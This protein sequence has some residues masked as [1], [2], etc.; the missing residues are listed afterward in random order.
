MLTIVNVNTTLHIY[1]RKIELRTVFQNKS[2]LR[3]LIEGG[4]GVGINGGLE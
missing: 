2:T 4:G 3:C 1:K